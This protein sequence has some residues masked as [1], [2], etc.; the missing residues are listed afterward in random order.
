MIKI[1]HLTNKVD[2]SHKFYGSLTALIEDNIN[3]N[4]SKA[5]LD[6]YDFSENTFENEVVIIRKSIVLTTGDIRNK[7]KT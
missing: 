2:N 5:K 3:I 6:R 7:T 1:F 4:V